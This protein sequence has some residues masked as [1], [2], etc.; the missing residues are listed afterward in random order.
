MSDLVLPDGSYFSVI[1]NVR[2]G[3]G[4]QTRLAML[5]HRLFRTHAG[6]ELPIVTYNPVPTYEPIRAEMR[7]TGQLMDDSPLIN[8]HE[9]LRVRDLTGLPTAEVA[10]SSGSFADEVE[11]GYAWRRQSGDVWEFLRPDGSLYAR[12][13]PTHVDGQ[14][15]I[16]DQDERPVGSWP[17]LGGLWRWWTRQIIPAEGRVFLISDSRF[18]ADELGLLDDPR[19]HLMHQ[20]HNPHLTGARVW[21]SPVSE[22]YK[23]S[24]DHIR[25]YDGLLSLT[26]RQRDDIALRYGAT[27]NLF[28][29]PNPVEPVPEPDPLPVRR[30]HAIAMIARLDGQKRIDRAIEAFDLV[31]AAV[32]EATLD[33]YGD[34]ELR[35]EL[36]AR[37][38]AARHGERMTLHGHDPHARE[39]LWTASLFWLTSD[40]EGYPLSTL[41]A[42]S[43]GVPVVSMDMPYGPREQITDGVDGGLVPFGDVD[44]LANRT[45]ELLGSDLEPMRTAARAK[46]ADHDHR[47]FLADWQH[48]LEKVVE[49][50]VSRV[51]P[52]SHWSVAL[53]QGDDPVTVRGQ[54]ELIGAGDDVELVAQAWA[55]N[56][57][58]V[59]TIPLHVESD[60]SFAGTLSRAEIPAN[61]QLRVGYVWRNAAEFVPIPASVRRSARSVIGAAL[62]RTG[63]R[64]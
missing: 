5:R 36:K 23:S 16:F 14:V 31:A 20:M 27:N 6:V 42:M 12:T 61:G 45:V 9:D 30:P 32:P 37:I 22:S 56:D 28:V 50:K 54:L 1:G 25:R 51:Q 13:P 8:L 47:R 52:R 64:K 26:E 3:A 4:G 15:A 60:L 11:D 40:F 58:A 34:G 33:V 41:E 17:T 10:A 19:I 29:V 57:P 7:R 55:P 35:D 48:V 49:L 53:D 44:A 62:R 46:A 43:H 21:S 63:L 38:D 59:V 39:A 18:V 2:I 24:M